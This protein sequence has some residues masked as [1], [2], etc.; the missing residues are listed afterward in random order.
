MTPI[1][2]FGLIGLGLGL[3]LGSI[4]FSLKNQDLSLLS[5]SMVS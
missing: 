2:R 5:A 4:Y 1:M 3:F